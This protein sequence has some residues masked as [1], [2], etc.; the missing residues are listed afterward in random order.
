[1]LEQGILETAGYEVDTASSGEEALEKARR[2][3]YGVFIVDVEMPGMDGFTFIQTARA[4]PS[5]G[6]HPVHRGDLARLGGRPGPRR[7]LGAT[8]YIVKSAFDEVLLLK[9]IRELVG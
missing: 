6:G 7:R 4:E 2:R 9:T 5:L 3:R 1:M 8:A